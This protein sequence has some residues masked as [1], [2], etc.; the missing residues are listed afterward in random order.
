[1]AEKVCQPLY[2]TLRKVIV[3]LP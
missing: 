3:R 2:P 1:V